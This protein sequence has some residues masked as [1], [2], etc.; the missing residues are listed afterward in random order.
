MDEHL[1]GD[2][3]G[4]RYIV[5]DVKVRLPA[6]PESGRVIVGPTGFVLLS[7][8]AGQRWPIFVNRDEADTRSALPTTAELDAL[9]GARTGVDVEVGICMGFYLQDAERGGSSDGAASC[10]ASR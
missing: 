5:A 6:P 7:A 9:L 8:A 1:A 10:W 2:T 4:G 3:Y